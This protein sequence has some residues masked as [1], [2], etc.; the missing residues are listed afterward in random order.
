MCSSKQANKQTSSAHTYVVFEFV[1]FVAFGKHFVAFV[2]QLFGGGGFAVT[3]HL[4]GHF[5]HHHRSLLQKR[6]AR[7][8]RL[9]HPPTQHTTQH[10]VATQTFDQSVEQMDRCEA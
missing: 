9:S 10:T 8:R 4:S 5:L 7:H 6:A 2:E 3:R 1:V